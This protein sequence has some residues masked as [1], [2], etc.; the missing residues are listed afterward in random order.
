M[1]MMGHREG[2]SAR[3]SRRRAGARVRGRVAPRRASTD[4][5]C[6]TRTA[7]RF[8]AACRA[9]RG[10]AISRALDD[11]TRLVLHALERQANH[12]PRA[13]A[14]EDALREERMLADGDGRVERAMALAWDGLGKMH[15]A[16]AMRLFVRTLEEDFPEWWNPDAMRR[17]NAGMH[18]TSGVEEIP[19]ALARVERGRWEFLEYRGKRPLPRFQHGACVAG[20]KMYVVG[21]SYRGRFMSDAH[22]LDLETGEWRQLEASESSRK[23]GALPPCAGHRLVSCAGS[24]YLVGGRFKTGASSSMAI[25]RMDLKDGLD[26]VEWTRVDA[27]GEEMPCARRGASVTVAGKDTLVVFGGEDEERRFLNDTWILDLKAKEWRRVKA[28]GGHPPDPRADHTATMWGPDALLV[29]GGTGRSNRCHD[30]LHALDLIHHKWTAV[31]PRGTAQPRAG[32]AGILLKDGRYWALIGGG[33]NVRGLSENAI[34]DLDEMAWVPSDSLAAPPVVGEGMT[35]CVVSTRD[36]VDDA[37][38]AFGGYNGSCQNETQALRLAADFPSS[39]RAELE[40]KTSA[41][42]T[43]EKCSAN[44]ASEGD[45]EAR[46]NDEGGE[47][48][49]SALIAALEFGSS[50]PKAA[51]SASV[52]AFGAGASVDALRQE[53]AELRR[54]LHR[55]RADAKIIGDAHEKLR[56]R[57]AQLERDVSAEKF[58]SADLEEKIAVLAAEFHASVPGVGAPILS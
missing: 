23:G 9:T 22:E 48:D 44:N 46:Q 17:T 28:P 30:T 36:G 7:R 10:T 55:L 13:S 6:G 15:A 25:Y 34:L 52:F 18:A 16:E 39:V 37:V 58:R 1:M 14:S 31:T 54:A 26:E 42:E 57:C 53:N 4:G 32:H 45:D 8:H 19:S 27:R 21:G 20:E 29:F 47:K 41:D 51:V 3:A 50:P 24:V 38:I 2:V 11:E 12:G 35:I 43:I 33:N 56:A 5:V 49:A 40:D